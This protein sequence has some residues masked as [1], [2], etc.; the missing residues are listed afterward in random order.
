MVEYSHKV[1]YKGGRLSRLKN[2]GKILWASWT[3]TMLL[4]GSNCNTPPKMLIMAVLVY[5]VYLVR[6]VRPSNKMGQ[7][8]KTNAITSILFYF[9]GFF[10]DHAQRVTS[11]PFPDAEA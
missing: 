7:T 3:F 1:R 11:H 9:G 6:F 2:W 5:P 8:S 4:T 10:Q